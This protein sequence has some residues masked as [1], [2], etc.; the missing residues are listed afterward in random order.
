MG[1]KMSKLYEQNPVNYYCPKCKETGKTPNL[2]G[3]FFI[4]N[5]TEC[6]CN[7]CKTI[8]PK[9]KMYKPVVTGAKLINPKLSEQPAN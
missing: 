2:A 5:E 3:R 1:G 9:S 4:I 8:Y 6:E 7:G